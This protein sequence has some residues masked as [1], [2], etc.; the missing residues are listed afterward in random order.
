MKLEDLIFTDGLIISYEEV[1]N[2]LRLNF[3]DYSD[4]LIEILFLGASDYKDF[5]FS[6][7][8]IEDY[9]INKKRNKTVLELFDDEENY[10][11][12]VSFENYK[13]MFVEEKNN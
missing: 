10:I 4:N 3:S 12:Q 1:F 7:R 5:G 9:K 8:T 11:F 13:I 6:G 2:T